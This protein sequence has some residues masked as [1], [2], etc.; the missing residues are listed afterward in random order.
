M[1][2]RVLTIYS[3]KCSDSGKLCD[4][5]ISYFSALL[6]DL[7]FLKSEIL[8]GYAA[9][10]ILGMSENSQTGTDDS[11]QITRAHRKVT[12]SGPKFSETMIILNHEFIP[13]TFIRKLLRVIL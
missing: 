5:R 13:K 2:T 7:Q 10:D 3:F 4:I 8:A 6:N 12:L 11:L 1:Q 9:C